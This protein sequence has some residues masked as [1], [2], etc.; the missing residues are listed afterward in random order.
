MKD[1]YT[2]IERKREK[3][4]FF[5][6]VYVD[7]KFVDKFVNFND[8]EETIKVEKEKRDAR[9]KLFKISFG[10][11]LEKYNVNMK[12]ENDKVLVTF[13]DGIVQSFVIDGNDINSKVFNVE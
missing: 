11:V 2:G 7:G 6:Y 12:F 5:Y 10:S 8:A 9:I 3:D 13:D 4:R 1:N